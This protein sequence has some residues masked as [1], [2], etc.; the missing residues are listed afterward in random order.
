[1]DRNELVMSLHHTNIHGLH[2]TDIQKHLKFMKIKV[3]KEKKEVLVSLLKK[4]IEPIY[5]S[6]I[7][8]DPSDYEYCVALSNK[9]KPCTNSHIRYEYVCRIHKRDIPTVL[10]L[11][12]EEEY[13]EDIPL[14]IPD[15]IEQEEEYI[16]DIPLETPDAIDIIEIEPEQNEYYD[17]EYE[18][19][20]LEE[21]Q[22]KFRIVQKTFYSNL[23]ELYV[24]RK[25]FNKVK[26]E[27]KTLELK[28]N[29]LNKKLKSLNIQTV[30]LSANIQDMVS[31][32]EN[33]KKDM[34]KKDLALL[35]PVDDLVDEYSTTTKN[36][37]D[38]VSIIW[39]CVG[40]VFLFIILIGCTI[41]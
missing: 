9:G 20:K 11:D 5:S 23:H 27:R 18:K 35:A 6:M 34:I 15:A 32:E 4:T 12:Q 39:C 17:Q 38:V 41:N 31:R 40:Y 26:A 19:E 10:V 24:S 33:M 30:C 1:M 37:A 13:I 36:G 8:K 7:K 21:M 16:E 3:S 14:E 25:E 22:E 28:L 2:K 29:V